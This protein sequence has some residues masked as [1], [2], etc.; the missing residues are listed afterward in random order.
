MKRLRFFLFSILL[1]TSAGCA[2]TYGPMYDLP[3]VPTNEAA[4]LIIIRD[5]AII[6]SAAAMVI[7]IDRLPT[8]ALPTGSYIIRKIPPGTHI[9]AADIDVRDYHG[10]GIIKENMATIVAKT[11]EKIYLLTGPVGIFAY[12]GKISQISEAQGKELMAESEFLPD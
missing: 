3:A 5:K 8:Y 12:R 4:E 2:A 11:G 9:I 7:S 10:P 6:A 1:L